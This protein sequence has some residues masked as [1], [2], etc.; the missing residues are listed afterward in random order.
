MWF[1]AT[2]ILARWLV[3]LVALLGLQAHTLAE[4]N[5]E[6][7][8]EVA[9]TLSLEPSEGISGTEVIASGEGYCGSTLVTLSWDHKVQLQSGMAGDDGNISIIF[10]VPEDVPG[11]HTVTSTSECGGAE[12]IFTVE[13]AVQGANVTTTETPP[14]PTTEP[15][16]EPPPTTELPPTTEPGSPTTEPGLPTTTPGS[17]PTTEVPGVGTGSGTGSVQPVSPPSPNVIVDDYGETTLVRYQNIIRH[18]LESG[19]ILYNPP[20]SM[21]VGVVNRIEVRISRELSDE[22]AE[23]L[24]GTADPHLDE[25]LVGT[26]MR[27]RLEGDAFDVTLIGSDTQQL[28]AKGF[29]EWRWDVTPI[30]S[31]R[32]P[33]FFTVSVLHEAYPNPIEERVFE[34]QIDVEVNTIYSLSKWLA[35]NW[36]TPIAALAGIIGIF[37]GRRRL[38]L[39]RTGNRTAT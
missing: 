11:Q 28:A 14:P 6:S 36:E 13:E 20:E 7:D 8:Q 34:R 37:E 18:E 21:Q 39:R 29:R 12:V 5:S 31:G 30:A 10:T 27:A 24:Q 1:G 23:G 25:L 35:S 2:S 26:T 17:P 4:T 16:R 22:L 19:V 38:R 15:P 33:L 9:P 32:N 3:A